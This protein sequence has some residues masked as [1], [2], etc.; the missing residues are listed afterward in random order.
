MQNTPEHRLDDGVI[1]EIA[2]T[3]QEI[4]KKYDTLAIRNLP[5]KEYLVEVKKNSVNLA[6]MIIK[7]ADKSAEN[8]F[9]SAVG[10]LKTAYSMFMN[11]INNLPPSTKIFILATLE[12]SLKA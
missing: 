2:T 4:L 6:R 8:D 10:K 1:D 7:S 5:L 12:Y 11:E 9:D 3:F